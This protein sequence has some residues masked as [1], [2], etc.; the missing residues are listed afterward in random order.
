M[1]GK[2]KE[3]SKGKQ[4]RSKQGA[5]DP[6]VSAP[7]NYINR[8]LSW[9]RFNERV[10]EEAKNTDNPLFERLKFLSIAA[11]NLDE[12]VMVRVAALHDMVNADIRDRDIA[13][14]S[15][16]QQLSAVTDVLH[17][18]TDD[19]YGVFRLQALPG[20]DAEGISFVIDAN[21]LS[22]QEAA[23][24]DRYFEEEVYPVL[25]P[26]A[27]DA[28]RPF[29]LVR[30]RA[31]NIG[32]LVRRKEGGKET[33]FCMVQVPDVLPRI[34]TLPAGEDGIRRMILLERVIERNMEKLFL[35][36]DILCMH[37]FRV[38]RSADFDI[39]EDDASDLLLEI[40]KQL[41]KRRWG[42]ALML[43]VEKTADRRLVK[44]LVRE[45]R[46]DDGELYTIDGPL[47][48]TFLMKLYAMD[49]FSAFKEHGYAQPAPVPGLT[50]EDDIFA[51]VR[52]RDIL[53]HHPYQSFSP[54][55]RFVEEAAQD[56][57]V[58]AIK[59][60]LYRV[61]GNSPIIA[62]L[63]RA[64][65]HGKQVSVLV[66][67]K[68]R[69]DEENNIGWARMLEKAGCHVI[70]GLAGL[71]THCKITLVVRREAD[72]IRRY[73]HLGTG[74]YNDTTARLYTDYGLFTCKETYGADA[75]AVFNMLSGF[76]E[77]PVW[78]RL[79][80]APFWLKD[81]LLYLI[82]REKEHAQN[83]EPARIVAKMNSLCHRDV[84]DALYE[85]GRAGVQIDLIIRGICSLRAGVPGLSDNITVRSIVGN[86]LEHAR[87]FY[88][89]NGYQP[90]VYLSSADWMPR[91]LERR[92]ELMF[93]VEEEAL[94]A[95]LFRALET[96]LADTEKSRMMLEDGTYVPYRGDGSASV[97]AQKTFCQEAAQMNRAESVRASRVFKPRRTA[98]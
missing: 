9:L 94:R 47:D 39:D 82:G 30:N 73:V 61:S 19:M 40:E 41:K 62:A 80:P 67:L 11:S 32:A 45:L 78:N 59:Q 98:G 90:E 96:E 43:E 57:Q 68:A 92:V 83:G 35:N 25:T 22:K 54:V 81:R 29:P 46:V 93:P 21:T 89:E 51:A 23:F 60:T 64:A 55:V 50:G 26:M 53:M 87:V 48:L 66:E 72:G 69:F 70:Y 10:L 20:L 85:A 8:E 38:L 49:G 18:F 79:V 56:P 31:L 86:F 42:K 16:K 33:D 4:K 2:K 27:V 24:V 97:N 95:R 77:P 63:A 37:A 34:L 5:R 88:F 28:S 76:S 52:K 65:D 13:G 1:A 7:E 17:T 3:K 6:Y 71:K 58:L 15:A 14:M 75:T 36:Y 44:R 74:N 91:N 84:I 12:F